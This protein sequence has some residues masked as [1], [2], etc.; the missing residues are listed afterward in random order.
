[1]YISTL[2]YIGF[3]CIFETFKIFQNSVTIK[4]APLPPPLPH[5]P[6]HNLHDII[7]KHPLKKKSYDVVELANV[8]VVCPRDPGSNLGKDIKYF[9]ILHSAGLISNL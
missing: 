3:Y 5:T 6:K 8:S 9:V 1:M 2:Q 4:L 7:D